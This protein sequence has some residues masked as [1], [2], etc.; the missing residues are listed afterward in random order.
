MPHVRSGGFLIWVIGW[1]SFGVF[2]ILF[3]IARVR[4]ALQEFSGRV[5]FDWT[6]FALVSAGSCCLLT[7]ICTLRWSFPAYGH[8]LW[9]DIRADARGVLAFFGRRG[10]G[11]G[12]PDG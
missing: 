8:T 11:Q 5:P 7:F 1:A 4:V 6:R 9:D 12:G 3:A 2:T 10:S